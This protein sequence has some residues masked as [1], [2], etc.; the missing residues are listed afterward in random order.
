MSEENSLTETIS[1]EKPKVRE[2]QVSNLDIK[3]LIQLQGCTRCGECLNWCPVYDQDMREAILPRKKIQD[4]LRIV[5][6]QQGLLARI[7][8]SGRVGD[9][10]KKLLGRGLRLSGGRAGTDGGIRPQ[11]V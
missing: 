6:S 2:L 4:F 8:K 7:I 10:L 3:K 9:P 11:S 1:P 5:K